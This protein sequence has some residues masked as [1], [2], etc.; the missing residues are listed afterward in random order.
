MIVHAQPY[1]RL[2]LGGESRKLDSGQ[3]CGKRK[4]RPE[5]RTGRSPCPCGYP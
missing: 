4:K 5:T 1:W 2:R 3:E